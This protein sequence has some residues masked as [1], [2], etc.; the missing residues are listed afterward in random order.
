MKVSDITSIPKTSW[1][2]HRLSFHSNHLGF[3]LTIERNMNF[4]RVIS[5]RTIHFTSESEHFETL[6]KYFKEVGKVV[7]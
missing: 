5:D 6:E 2:F 7:G 4:F 3:N 1:W